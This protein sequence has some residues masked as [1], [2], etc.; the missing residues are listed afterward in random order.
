MKPNIVIIM[1]TEHAR[2]FTD[3]KFESNAVQGIRYME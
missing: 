1:G 3:T 2:H